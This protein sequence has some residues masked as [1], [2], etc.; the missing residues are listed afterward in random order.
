M[1]IFIGY[2]YRLAVKFGGIFFIS[3]WLKP[4]KLKCMKKVLLLFLSI[5]AL[6]FSQSF[7]ATVTGLKDSE[8]IENGYVVL[9]FTGK[10]AE[11]LYDLTNKFC[12]KYYV[13][14]KTAL[15]SDIKNEYL[16]IATYEK[17]FLVL[18]TGMFGESYYSDL[19]FAANFSFK[20]SKV[21]FEVS[22]LKMYDSF[23]EH[24]VFYTSPGGLTWCIFKSNGKT[25]KNLP[26]VFQKYFNKYIAD[27]VLFVNEYKK[28]NDNW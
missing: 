17:Q 10:S 22:E 1:I 24:E 3:L 7:V 13:G 27:Y 12:Q 28:T 15:K 19:N 25:N 18:Q 8:K 20:D 11:Q 16:K 6:C 4:I 23:G 14:P 9:S 5:P 26:I 21:K 2:S